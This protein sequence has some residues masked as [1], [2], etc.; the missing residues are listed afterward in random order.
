MLLLLLIIGIL[1]F[2][3]F[4]WF[5]V[6]S[7]IEKEPLATKRS[8]VLAALLSAP[9]II[10]AFNI[11]PNSIL[12]GEI[13]LGIVSL[14]TAILIFPYNKTV[15]I[16]KENPHLRF[17]E[18]DTMFSR[19]EITRNPELSEKYYGFRPEKLTLDKEWHTKP[20]LMSE[21]SSMYSPLTFAAADASFFAI[22]QLRPFV[23]TDNH[24]NKKEIDA[25][26]IS[27]FI[28]KW[29]KKIGAVSIGF[30]EIQDYHYYS[31]RGRGDY[32]GKK[33]T[34]SYKYGIAF[35]VEMDKDFLATGPAGPTLMES[36]QQYLNSGT[37][38]IQIAKFISNLGYEARAHI[39][40]NY[41]LIAPLVA[42]DAGLGEIGRMGLLMTPMLGPRIRIAVVTTDI[43][44]KITKRKPN[45]T[46]HD[47]CGIC[48]KCADVCPSQAIPK[49][50]L[51]IIDGV[52]RWKINHE[53]CFGYWCISGTDCGRCMSVCPYSHPNNLLHNI[54]RWGIEHS[55]A[56]RR[57][58]LFMDDFFYSRKPKPAKVPKWIEIS[59]S[60]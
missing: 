16:T 58:A 19:N 2:L 47:F 56:F 37:I 1:I 24:R 44:L 40:G 20:G 52:Q 4:T 11:I 23:K 27:K 46:V 22:E 34:S 8:L 59:K 9:F 3:F 42:R 57:F 25:E 32:Y 51:Q 15:K 35:T 13:L 30:C 36:A 28:T 14:I 48:K 29:A 33:V 60:A 21:K 7:V 54:V 12:A 10:L 18:R 41:E 45:Y 31:V 17:D 26:K 5:A 6:V 38:A 49:T 50:P 55:W 39:D 53:K 43:P